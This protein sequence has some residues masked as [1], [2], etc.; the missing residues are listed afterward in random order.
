MLTVSNN[1]DG[2]GKSKV[3]I[4]SED[5]LHVSF[6]PDYLDSIISY[7]RIIPW[8][9]ISKKGTSGDVYGIK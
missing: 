6:L 2:T 4:A 9:W 5:D 7:L 1:E 3:F 8:N